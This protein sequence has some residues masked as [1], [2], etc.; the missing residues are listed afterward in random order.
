MYVQVIKLYGI[1]LCKVDCINNN[2]QY[3]VITF[4]ANFHLP[5]YNILDKKILKL[6]LPMQT[7]GSSPNGIYVYGFYV[8]LFITIKSIRSK[9]FWV[10]K[11]LRVIM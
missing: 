3:T 8:L 9:F 7:R 1:L 10:R 11:V 5:N 4:S 2:Q 6:K